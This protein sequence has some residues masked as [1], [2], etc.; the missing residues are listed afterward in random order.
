MPGK[1]APDDESG[2]SQY[3]AD[4]GVQKLGRR[5]APSAMSGTLTVIIGTLVTLGSS[6]CGT[7]ATV[8]LEPALLDTTSPEPRQ[9]IH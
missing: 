6:G 8:E 7:N 3:S 2:E 9:S 4:R 1:C 5:T